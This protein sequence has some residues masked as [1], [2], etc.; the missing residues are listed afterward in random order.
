MHLPA[1]LQ[2]KLLAR[3]MVQADG[4]VVLISQFTGLATRRNLP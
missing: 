3:H 4:V 1:V 2:Y